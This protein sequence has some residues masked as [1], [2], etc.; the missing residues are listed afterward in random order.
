M[1]FEYDLERVRAFFAGDRFAA[2]AGASVDSVTDDEVVCSLEIADKHRNA[3]GAVQGGA[4]FTLADLC[5]AVHC[6]QA[7]LRGEDVGGTV[8]QSCSISY[9][10]APRGTKL[11]ASS[12]RLSAGRT[13]SVY[14]VSVSDDLGN[15]V[16]EMICNGFAT[17]KRPEAR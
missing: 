6:T 17:A 7:L 8:G 13:M 10:K 5:F 12:R 15:A 11:I 1:S 14:G 4:I 2:L 3:M 9:L 16:A